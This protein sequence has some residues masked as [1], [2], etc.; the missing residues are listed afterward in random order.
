MKAI[1]GI[2][3][4]LYLLSGGSVFAEDTRG[5]AS[6]TSAQT[7]SDGTGT[8][9]VWLEYWY[10]ANNPNLRFSSRAAMHEHFRAFRDEGN[11]TAL[12][13]Q[14]RHVHVF[15]GRPSQHVLDALASR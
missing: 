15:N 14:A 11:D 7:R 1:C 5:N 6:K 13:G 9:E 8:G 12:L 10:F 3:V 2:T 4:V